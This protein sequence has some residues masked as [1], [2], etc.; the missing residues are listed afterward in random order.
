LIALIESEYQMSRNAGAKSEA[1]HWFDRIGGGVSENALSEILPRPEMTMPKWDL[2][3]GSGNAK[4]AC[5][6]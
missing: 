4:A 1:V 2:F 6:E 3:S 5:A